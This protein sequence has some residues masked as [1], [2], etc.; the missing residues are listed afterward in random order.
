VRVL[1][2]ENLPVRFADALGVHEVDTVVGLGW[3]GVTNGELLRRAAG[4][5]DAFVTMD[6]Q[7]GHQQAVRTL[8]FGVVLLLARSNRMTDLQ[9]LVPDLLRALDSVQPSNVVL[10]GA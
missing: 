9:P 10:V 5:F 6:K 1:L 2:D 3:A 4:R 8:P 7:L